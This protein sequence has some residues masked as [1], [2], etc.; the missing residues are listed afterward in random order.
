MY[1]Q[2]TS[3]AQ[4]LTVVYLGLT[5]VRVVLDMVGMPRRSKV[6][7]A[8]STFAIV[9]DPELPFLVSSKTPTTV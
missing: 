1:L 9:N 5:S 3:Y 4:R 2:M 6:I 8:I 7:L